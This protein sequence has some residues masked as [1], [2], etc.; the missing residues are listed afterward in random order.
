MSQLNLRG[1]GLEVL[2]Y[3]VVGFLAVLGLVGGFAASRVVPK[4]HRGARLAVGVAAGIGLPVGYLWWNRRR[5]HTRAVQRQA[6]V[7]SYCEQH[8]TECKQDRDGR[9]YAPFSPGTH[10]DP[11]REF[12]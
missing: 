3:A 2:G 10:N 11:C 5:L 12:A 6:C 7:R 4:K 1:G 8:P 9:W